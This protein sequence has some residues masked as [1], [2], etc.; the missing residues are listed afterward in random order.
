MLAGV[1]A[2]TLTSAT[3]E[4]SPDPVEQ[5]YKQTKKM[6]VKMFCKNYLKRQIEEFINC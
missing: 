5:A 6:H 4:T 2:Q 3:S 1:F